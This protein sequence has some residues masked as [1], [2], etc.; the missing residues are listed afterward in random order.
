MNVIS[1]VLVGLRGTALALDL[2]GQ[3]KSASLL[4]TLADAAEAGE[5]VDAHMAMIAEKLKQ[6]PSTD[7]DWKDVIER[8]EADRARLHSA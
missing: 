8:I 3:S 4:Y 1:L 6:R 7:A 2:Q 5:A